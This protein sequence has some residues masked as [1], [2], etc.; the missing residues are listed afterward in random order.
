MLTHLPSLQSLQDQLTLCH[1]FSA[2]A[3]TEAK[4]WQIFQ[5]CKVVCAI[6]NN[7]KWSWTSMSWGHLKGGMETPHNLSS[8]L[9]RLDFSLKFRLDS[10]FFPPSILSKLL[11]SVS[12]SRIFWALRVYSDCRPYMMWDTKPDPSVLILSRTNLTRCRFAGGG[13]VI[14]GCHASR[15]GKML[16]SRNVPKRWFFFKGTVVVVVVLGACSALKH[17]RT[18]YKYLLKQS[19]WKYSNQENMVYFGTHCTH[20]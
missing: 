2:A 20:T 1:P 11:R 15:L 10:Q 12:D 16:R 19:F 3:V 14:D 17:H 18:V 7:N 8:N 13:E 4:C 6:F 5:A 9:F